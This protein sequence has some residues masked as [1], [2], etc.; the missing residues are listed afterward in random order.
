MPAY[1]RAAEPPSALF[2]SKASEGGTSHN[3]CTL[4]LAARS[5]RLSSGFPALQAQELATG[6]WQLGVAPAA[7]LPC[8]SICTQQRA[9]AYTAHRRTARSRNL[10][11]L[12]TAP[13]YLRSIVF[14]STWHCAHLPFSSLSSPR[15][16][17]PHP[18]APP[19]TVSHFGFGHL[20][21][22]SNKLW[23]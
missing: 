12:D 5:L 2:L 3:S 4:H 19:L 14:T 7:L 1:R 20:G 10:R 8:L 9:A 17:P 15:P 21:A 22:F 16:H 13:T 11:Y 23:I 6:N 18:P